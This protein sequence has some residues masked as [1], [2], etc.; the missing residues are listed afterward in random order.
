MGIGNPRLPAFLWTIPKF[1]AF[2]LNFKRVL[3]HLVPRLPCPLIQDRGDALSFDAK[4]RAC[5]T[6]PLRPW[7]SRCISLA[8]YSRLSRL[9]QS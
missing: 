4:L 3:V 6:F 8:C 2:C 1:V 5:L 9:V 7:S